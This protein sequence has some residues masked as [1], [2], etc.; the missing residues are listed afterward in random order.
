MQK[1]LILGILF[2]VWGCQSATKPNTGNV[3]QQPWSEIEKEARGTTVN[4]MMWTGDPLINAYIQNYV[5]PNVKKRL[6]IDLKIASGQG[7]LIVQALL[8]ELQA[9]KTESELDLLWINGETFYQLRE[10][11]ALFGPWTDKLPNAQYI[12]FSNPFIGIDFQQP[13]DGFECPWGNVQMAL[14]YNSTQVPYPPQDRQAL[15]AFLK[16]HPGKFTFDNQFTGMTF[17]KSLL[18]DIAGGAKELEGGFDEKKY[19]TYSKELWAYLKNIQPYLWRAGKTFPENVAVI[20]QLYASGELWFT[21]SNNDNEV[22]NKVSQGLFPA[23]SRAYVWKS[24]LIQNTH[25]QGIPQLSKNKAGAMAVVNFLISPEAQLKKQDP[26]VW[27]DGMVLD[28][29]KLPQTWQAQ[30]QK[31]PP[32][33]YVAP[34]SELNARALPELAPQYMIRLSEDFRKNIIEQ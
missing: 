27:G 6:G 31:L 16:E 24:G 29:K 7:N 34:R 12:N 18:I 17:L 26:A 5:V 14:I 13:V 20:H 21:M 25:Y 9:G 11:D 15:A 19:L 33:K 4:L 23:A 3:L 1:L 2:L 32:R 10:I 8:A 22:D 30:W 28:L